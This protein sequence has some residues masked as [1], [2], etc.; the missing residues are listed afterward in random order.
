VSPSEESV[1]E[2]PGTIKLSQR[3]MELS[4]QLLDTPYSVYKAEQQAK[5][6][7]IAVVN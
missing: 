7:S 1:L 3:T 2:I 5:I 4:A 6:L